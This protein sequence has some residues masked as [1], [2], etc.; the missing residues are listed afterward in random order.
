[1]DRRAR[2]KPPSNR[3][4]TSEPKDL[5]TR[6][7]K[8]L[9]TYFENGRQIASELVLEIDGVRKRI[10]ELETENVSLR[11]Q[12]KSDHAIREL[13]IKIE[14]LEGERNG[15]LSRSA[16]VERQAQHEVARAAAVEQELS[17]LAS[18]YV[19]N[20]QLHATLDPR[21]VVQTIGQL[22]LQFVGAGSY[23]VYL[24]D[25]DRLIPVA[26]E[27]IAP[28]ELRAETIGEGLVG[29][30]FLTNDVLRV[31][32]D[33]PPPTPQVLV[34]LRVGDSRVGVVAIY[35][36]LEQKAEL[37]DADFEMLRMLATQGAS[38][39]VGAQFYAAAAGH[40]PPFQAL[41]PREGNR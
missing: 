22:I 12:L 36:L 27:G 16:E 2:A 4:R 23:A 40:V 32:D 6:R 30:A 35:A 15:L 17:N 25:G 37:A 33:S 14:A 24:V 20:A 13:I 34:P 28:G 7:K 26:C 1:M 3:P 38:A 5:L 21:E 31:T 18:L 10:Q 29:A 41:L 39:L 8:L 11:M 9:E 19:A